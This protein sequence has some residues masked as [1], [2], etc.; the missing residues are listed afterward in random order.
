LDLY[1]QVINPSSS[2]LNPITGTMQTD[3]I[4]Q[5]SLL[6]WLLRDYI[7][8]A[9]SSKFNLT[10]HFVAGGNL[11]PTLSSGSGGTITPGAGTITAIGGGAAV[12]PAGW[13]VQVA[14]G[15]A[16][17]QVGYAAPDA[18]R[19]QIA[20]PGV[21][22]TVRLQIADPTNFAALFDRITDRVGFDLDIQWDSAVLLNRVSPQLFIN[23]ATIWWGMGQSNDMSGE[24]YPQANTAGKF[25]IRP[26]KLSTVG[27]L[28]SLQPILSINVGASTG[29]VNINVS[30]SRAFKA[31]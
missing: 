25:G 9:I 7:A 8:Q 3:G 5:T 26:Y 14:A 22:A 23:G 30:T 29:A 31:T 27:S 12:V 16:N 1:S 4:H 11:L 2:V 21:A 24:V 15:T 10:Q 20:N 18:F 6:G 17:V 19:M 28:T 13:N